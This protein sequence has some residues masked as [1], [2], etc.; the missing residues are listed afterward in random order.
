MQII[1][2]AFNFVTTVTRLASET[3]ARVRRYE[4]TMAIQR[5]LPLLVLLLLSSVGVS[6]Q[7]AAPA[8]VPFVRVRWSGAT[9]HITYQTAKIDHDF[10]E[11][12][13]DQS[14]PEYE[15]FWFS[16]IDK[17]RTERLL[18]KDGKVYMLLDIEGPFPRT[19]R[20]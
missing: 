12:P 5:L 16:E 11:S 13:P 8:K 2:P 6:A 10:L 9:L 4:P 17:V 1:R 7:K 19:R 20:S 3:C 18:E 14:K 15:R